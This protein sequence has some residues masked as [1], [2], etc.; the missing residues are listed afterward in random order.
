[1]R[2]G[3]VE[4]NFD[5]LNESFRLPYVPE[6]IERKTGGPEKGKLD[7]ADVALHKREYE[8]LCVEL[9]AAFEQSSLPETVSS[10]A[11]THDLLVRVRL[12]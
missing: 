9:S 2:T 5:R 1:M 11:A 10:A 4:A 8:R 6:L 12:S 3:E 7:Q